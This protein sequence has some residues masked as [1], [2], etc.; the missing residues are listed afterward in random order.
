MAT[1]PMQ[2]VQLRS[3]SAAPAVQAYASSVGYT[4]LIGGKMARHAWLLQRWASLYELL[5]TSAS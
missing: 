5:V 4:L 3:K 1:V 2:I